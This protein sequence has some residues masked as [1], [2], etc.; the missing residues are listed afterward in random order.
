MSSH[1]DFKRLKLTLNTA[2]KQ[3]TNNSQRGPNLKTQH[4]PATKTLS[5]SL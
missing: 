4:E 5:T 1:E 3:K 2:R